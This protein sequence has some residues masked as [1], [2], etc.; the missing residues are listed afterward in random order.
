M[1]CSIGFLSLQAQ[2]IPPAEAGGSFTPSLHGKQ[3]SQIPP[4]EAGGS[5]TP[6]LQRRAQPSFDQGS[7]DFSAS[8]DVSRRLP[9]LINAFIGQSQ[10]IILADK[11]LPVIHQRQH[12]R[13]NAQF[14]QGSHQQ[15]R[16]IRHNR[17]SVNRKAIFA[18]DPQLILAQVLPQR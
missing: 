18:R 16:V 5:F 8:A 13:F 11:K 17:D 7:R 6:N 4:A 10:G 12:T 9:E 14:R 15:M 3:P 1:A 2:V